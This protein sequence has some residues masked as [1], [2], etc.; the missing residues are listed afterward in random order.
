MAVNVEHVE[1]P[2]ERVFAVLADADS[3][4]EWVVGARKIRGADPDFP[5]PGTKFHHQQG[6]GP[7]R[8]N[9]DTKVIE[10][11]PGESLVLHAR[12]RPFGTQKVTLELAPQGAGTKVTMTEEPGDPFTRL[13]FNPV[14]NL[15]LRGRNV[16]AL[17]RLK[18]LAEQP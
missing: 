14:F 4:A 7:I 2:P 15:L 16:E 18:N 5:A 13:V 6:I 1:A 3:Y 10:C 9:D 8:L 17:R 11:T 12:F